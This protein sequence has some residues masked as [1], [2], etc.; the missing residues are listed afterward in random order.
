MHEL[1]IIQNSVKLFSEYSIKVDKI[2]VPSIFIMTFILSLN[3]NSKKI[4]YVHIMHCKSWGMKT[5][6]FFSSFYDFILIFR[7][8][9][10]CKL[11]FTAFGL[12][13]D[14]QKMISKKF[15]SAIL[16]KIPTFYYIKLR[17]F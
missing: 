17:F 2:D 4:Q 5:P 6:F 8:F 10:M 3:K 11:V 14:C 13:L 7:L 1:R 12:I 9:Y 16:S 15:F